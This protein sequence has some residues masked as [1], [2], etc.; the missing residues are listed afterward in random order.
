[1]FRFC[2]IASVVSPTFHGFFLWSCGVVI[3]LCALVCASFEWKVVFFSC[4]AENCSSDGATT[5]SNNTIHSLTPAVLQHHYNN[6]KKSFFFRF[7]VEKAHRVSTRLTPFDR[8]HL[9]SLHFRFHSLEFCVCVG[10]ASFKV[11]AVHTSMQP[12]TSMSIRVD[13]FL[14]CS[15][16][17]RCAIKSRIVLHRRHDNHINAA[18]IRRIE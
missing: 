14:L 2:S 10:G 18:R 13:F 1:M 12:I 8:F 5:K 7:E 15:W 9:L 6:I 3:R 16:F 4:A 11:V 17:L